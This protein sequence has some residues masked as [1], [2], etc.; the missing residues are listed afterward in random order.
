MKSK[1]KLNWYLSILLFFVAG[2]IPLHAQEPVRVKTAS[3]S[4]IVVYPQRKAP[5]TV[6]SLNNTMISAEIRATIK[7]I[8]VN[9]GDIVDKDEVM[10]TLDCSEYRLSLSESEAQ[11]DSF[12]ARIKLAKLKLN[13]TEEL[14]QKQSIPEETRDERVSELSVLSSDLKASESRLN[15]AKLNVNRCLITSP[16]RALVKDRIASVG[17]LAKIGTELLDLVDLNNLEVSAQIF[18]Q[19]SYQLQDA[20]NLLFQHNDNYYPLKL[21]NI[22]PAINTQTRNQEVRLFFNKNQAL[23]GTAGKLI[24]HDKQAHLPGKYIISRGDKSGYFYMNDNNAHFKWVE[25]ASTG[26]TIPIDLSSNVQIITEG[27]YGLSEGMPVF[28]EN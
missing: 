26:R 1:G 12:N 21:K 4:E 9:I 14:L 25:S 11:I 6:V 24:W 20:G 18:S 23:P 7:H 8:N 17:Q 28:T 2:V 15:T 13:R 5:A 22:V 19:D 3:L 16:Y 10:M 27:Y